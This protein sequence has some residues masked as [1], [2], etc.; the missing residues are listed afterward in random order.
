MGKCLYSSNLSWWD[1]AKSVSRRDTTHAVIDDREES[2]LDA[3]ITVY[4]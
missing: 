1:T 2:Q 4:W 3:T